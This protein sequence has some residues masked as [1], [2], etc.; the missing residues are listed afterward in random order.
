MCIHADISRHRDMRTPMR[1]AH[2]R[3]DCNLPTT[4]NSL[5]LSH[6]LHKGEPLTPLAVL[7]GLAFNLGK[8]A[9]LYSSGIALMISTS[10]G[11]PPNPYFLLIFARMMFR[12]TLSPVLWALMSSAAIPEVTRRRV[13]AWEGPG[14]RWSCGGGRRRG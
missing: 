6:F 2:H 3:N 7:I 14:G 13:S 8:S 12:E 1:L 9:F 11:T 5:D 4:N 10:L